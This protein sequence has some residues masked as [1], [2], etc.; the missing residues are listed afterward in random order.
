MSKLNISQAAKTAGV[1]RSTIQRKIKQGELSCETDEQ[2]KKVIDI[3]E[4][5]RVYKNLQVPDA[6]P[7]G[8]EQSEAMR[9]YTT[10]DSAKMLQK[11]N[12]LLKEQVEDLRQE[13]EIAREREKELRGLAKGLQEEL[14]EQR[15]LLLPSP[16]NAKKQK[17]QGFWARVF[18]G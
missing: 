10:P 18:G 15:I 14:K 5:N 13:R 6:T 3:A 4:L 7:D 1:A 9:Q 2:G 8:V 17:K 11:E 16:E 12:T